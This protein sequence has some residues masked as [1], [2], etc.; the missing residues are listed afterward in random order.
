[1]RDLILPELPGGLPDDYSVTSIGR[2][3]TM[4]KRLP[5]M[6]GASIESFFMSSNRAQ[7]VRAQQYAMSLAYEEDRQRAIR[8]RAKSRAAARIAQ[9]IAEGRI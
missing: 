7:E 5:S 1:M 8:M 9:A 3:G 6:P 2:R 4:S